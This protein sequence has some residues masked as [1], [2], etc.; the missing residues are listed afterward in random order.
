MLSS[1][2]GWKAVVL[3]EAKEVLYPGES[4]ARASL[5]CLGDTENVAG[6]SKYKDAVLEKVLT[7]LCVLHI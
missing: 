2:E 3:S 6:Y 4:D 1:S 5:A 7:G